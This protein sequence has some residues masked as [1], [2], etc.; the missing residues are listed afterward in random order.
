MKF[1]YNAHNE[2]MY[3]TD[4]ALKIQQYNLTQR[5]KE[6]TVN[7]DVANLWCDRYLASFWI[8]VYDVGKHIK[9]P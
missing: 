6:L 7:G 3:A 2:Y 1:D 8:F 9:A 4:K 5:N